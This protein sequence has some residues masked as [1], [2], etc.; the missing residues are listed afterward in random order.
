LT[1]NYSAH[2]CGSAIPGS[3]WLHEVS[4]SVV[5][6]YQKSASERPCCTV[7]R[8]ASLDISCTEH[9]IQ[10]IASESFCVDCHQLKQNWLTCCKSG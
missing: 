1:T 5:V 3:L 7:V 9:M 2:V 6:E 8:S 4:A 10:I